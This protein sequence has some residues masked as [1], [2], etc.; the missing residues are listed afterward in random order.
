[1]ATAAVGS[2]CVWLEREQQAKGAGRQ[3]RLRLATA[4]AGFNIG[5]GSLLTY[6]TG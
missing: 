6:P 1:M 3:Q 2:G 4:A 5:R